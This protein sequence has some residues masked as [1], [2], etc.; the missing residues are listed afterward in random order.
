MSELDK[1]DKRNQY[2]LFVLSRDVENIKSQISNLKNEKWKFIVADIRWHTV[3]EQLR[4]PE[5]LNKENLDLVHFPYFSVPIFYN[6]PFVVTIHD[7]IINHFP[8]GQASTLP[9]PLYWFKLQAYKY[10]IFQAASRAKR[11]ITVSNATK[12]EVIDHFKISSKDVVVTYEGVGSEVVSDVQ[13]KCILDIKNYFLY[14]GNAY[15]H[16]N[17][18][19]LID[20]F[21]I[22]RKDHKDISLVLIGRDDFFYRKLR[23]Q[24]E[25]TPGVIFKN[26]ATDQELAC[27]YKHAKALIMPSLMEG[28]GLTPLEAMAN[29]CV[30]LASDIPSLREICNNAAIYFDPHDVKSIARS[31]HSV[32]EKSEPKFLDDL[33]KKGRG[34]VASFSWRKMAEETIAVYESCNSV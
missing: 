17:L 25:K 2:V 4:F 33:R 8:T 1:V 14:V 19:R 7:L 20:A 3:E 30:V 9:Y 22:I 12:Q 31:M 21:E 24:H 5:V 10:V 18:Q 34:R 28:F 15:P 13:Y 23:G 27:Y 11:V 16:K 29:A 32:L 6:R 26:V